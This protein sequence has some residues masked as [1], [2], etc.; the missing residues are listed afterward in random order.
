[1]AA[2]STAD[3]NFNGVVNPSCTINVTT[4]GTLVDDGSG[5]L[6]SSATGGASGVASIVCNSAAATLQIG[7]PVAGTVAATAD[8]LSASAELTGANTGTITAGASD[9]ANLTNL[10]TAGAP[11]TVTVDMAANFNTTY[12][13][14][15]PGGNYGYAVTLT[16]T[17]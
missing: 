9:T 16:L 10:S 2:P 5:V 7:S 3:V 13:T 12:G 15:I 8:A 4:D 1:L 6:S 14:N 11:T 17:P